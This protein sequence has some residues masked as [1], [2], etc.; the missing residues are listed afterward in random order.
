MVDRRRRRACEK[1][2]KAENAARWWRIP[3]YVLAVIFARM[4]Y[5]IARDSRPQRPRHEGDSDHP[6]PA[7]ATRS[8]RPSPT[9]RFWS[10]RSRACS[11]TW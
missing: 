7:R 3:V 9:C 2:E 8:R 5:M 11:P 6:P 10:R 4:A 1:Q